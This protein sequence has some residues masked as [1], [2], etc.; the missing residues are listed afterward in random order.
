MSGHVEHERSRSPGEIVGESASHDYPG[1][2]HISTLNTRLR[3]P[4]GVS[5]RP[6]VACGHLEISCIT[7]YTNEITWRFCQGSN[8]EPWDYETAALLAKPLGP[9]D[10]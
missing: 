6:A 8:P 2:M 4:E 7:L 10:N 9:T 1:I 3:D 5:S